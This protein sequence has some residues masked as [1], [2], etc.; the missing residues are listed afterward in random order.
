MNIQNIIKYISTKDI[1]FL[2]DFDKTINI[3]KSGKCYYFKFFQINLDDITNFILNLKD[4]EIYTV[5]P[6][7]SVNCR[8]N[9]PQL[10]LSRKFLITNKSNPVL[11]YNYL[12]QQF[13]I[14]RDEF[15]IIE[16]HYFLILNYKRV[17]IDY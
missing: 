6:F 8:I 2:I 5:T 4:N 13:N 9:N 1:T 3:D 14:A 16:S 17:Q 7:I 12:T 15:Y 10:I 11:I